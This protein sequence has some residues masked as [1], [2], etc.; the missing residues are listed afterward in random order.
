MSFFRRQKLFNSALSVASRQYNDLS[1]AR[2]EIDMVRSRFKYATNLYRKELYAHFGC[3]NAIE[4]SDDGQFMV[5]GKWLIENNFYCEAL[6][7]SHNTIFT[8]LD[9]ICCLRQIG[10]IKN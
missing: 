2:N 8:D 1:F 3:V 7:K 4:F 6:C 10:F 5:S 9:F